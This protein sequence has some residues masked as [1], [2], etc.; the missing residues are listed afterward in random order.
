MNAKR[1]RMKRSL[2]IGLA[3]VNATVGD[4]AGNSARVLDFA[5]RAREN[6]VDIVAFPE[7]VITG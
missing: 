5:E 2:R 3:Q 6:D 7:L 1:D 4:L